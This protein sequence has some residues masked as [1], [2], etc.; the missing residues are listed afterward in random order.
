MNFTMK[1]KLIL[2]IGISSLLFLVVFNFAIWSNTPPP[3][4]KIVNPT[5]PE[6]F[7][8]EHPLERNGMVYS[9]DRKR[10][11]VCAHDKQTG[12]LVWESEGEDGFIIPGAAF[13][14]DLTPDGEL[15]VANVGL[16]RLEQ[17]DPQTGRFIAS[18]QPREAFPGCCNPIRFAALANGRFLTLEKGT[19]QACIYSPSGDLE[20]VVSNT[21]SNSEDN[22]YLYRTENAVHVF[23]AGTSQQLEITNE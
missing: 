3:P 4:A 18:W 9:V 13:P 11:T 5:V 2:A 19:Q 12:K 21:L 17:L 16:K 1:E 7:R 23:D 8:A 10:E 6:A 20:R 22:Y 15:W 14:L